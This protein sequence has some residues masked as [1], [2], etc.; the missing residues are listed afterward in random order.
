MNKEKILFQLDDWVS[1][2]GN[3][4]YVHIDFSPYPAMHNN[5]LNEEVG[6]QQNREELEKFIDVLLKS[7]TKSCLEIGLGF[8]GSTHFLWRQIYDKVITIE[9]N[10]ER[11]REFGRNTKKFY[12]DWILK[13]GRSQ[14][15]VGYSNDEKII[16]DVYSKVEE[17]D[18][19]FIDGN[20]SYESVLCDFLLYYPLVK[21]GGIIGFHDTALSEDN[22]GVPQL[23]AEIK[24]GKYTN[25]QRIN[26][27][28]IVENKW[29]GISYFY[30]Q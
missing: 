30:K 3:G 15:F 17:L 4:G 2:K 7:D 13:D 21:Q 29:S 11:I 22:L 9:K 28:D 1:D 6:I 25:G 18:L 12:C 24:T 27:I 8:F 20:H 16:A 23:I 19:L 14:F 5:H 10:F 26:V